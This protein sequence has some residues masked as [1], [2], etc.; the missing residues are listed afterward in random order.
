MYWLIRNI[1]LLVLYQWKSLKNYFVCEL[2][3]VACETTECCIQRPAWS[4]TP[5]VKT[6]QSKHRHVLLAKTSTFF[7]HRPSLRLTRLGGWPSFQR[8]SFV[9]IRALNTLYKYR[10]SCSH[11]KKMVC[12]HS[13]SFRL[14]NAFYDLAQSYY[15]GECRRVKAHK[16]NFTSWSSEFFSIFY[17]LF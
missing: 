3:D 16:V 4:K 11:V 6:R 2:R 7:S 10:C 1:S 8:L 14:E 15:H 12:Y 9:I 17:L 5:A 13:I